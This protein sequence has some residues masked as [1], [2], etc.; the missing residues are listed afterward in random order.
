MKDIIQ[1]SAYCPD[2][3]R[4]NLLRNLINSLS[5]YNHLFDLMVIS[6]TPIP[7]D[8]QKKV[9]LVIYDKKK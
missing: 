7:L 5:K 6:H 9:D 8:I 2:D 4:E 1:I 3:Y